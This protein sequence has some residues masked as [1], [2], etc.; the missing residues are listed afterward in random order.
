MIGGEGEHAMD[1]IGIYVSK[2]LVWADRAKNLRIDVQLTLANGGRKMAMVESMELEIINPPMSA[3]LKPDVFHKINEDEKLVVDDYWHPL[4]L[5][6]RDG[7]VKRVCFAA[8]INLNSLAEG[9][10]RALLKVHVSANLNATKIKT[11]EKIIS[12]HFS[13]S[14]AVKNRPVAKRGGAAVLPFDLKLLEGF[15]AGKKK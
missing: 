3:I 2:V 15:F 10:I 5:S 11:F 12:F 14:D 6:P 13:R 4:I 1:R 8:D 7:V 9:E